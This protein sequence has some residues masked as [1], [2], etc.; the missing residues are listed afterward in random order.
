M[1]RAHTWNFRQRAMIFVEK[2]KEWKGSR[3]TM[4]GVGDD[5]S[6]QLEG[7]SSPS[8]YDA[9]VTTDLPT[10]MQKQHDVDA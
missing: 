2:A 6:L 4:I 9:S 1:N 7:M 3:N 10:L 8:R 5:M